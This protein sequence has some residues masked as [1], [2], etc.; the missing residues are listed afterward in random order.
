MRGCPRKTVDEVFNPSKVNNGGVAI[1][2][3]DFASVEGAFAKSLDNTAVD[4]GGTIYARRTN[5][6]PTRR[7]FRLN[8]RAS[9]PRPRV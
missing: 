7:L 8:T 3:G 4:I 6:D 5:N 1:N 2:N 9:S